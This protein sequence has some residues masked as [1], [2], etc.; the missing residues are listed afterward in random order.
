MRNIRLKLSY[1]LLLGLGLSGLH[2]QES[3]NA[4]GGN[5]SGSGGSAAYSIGQVVCQFSAGT[6]GSEAQGVQQPYEISVVTTIKE[7]TGIKLT[8]FAWP[9]P[10]AGPLT[11]CIIEP[12]FSELSY[13]LSDLNGKILLNEKIKSSRTTIIMNNR[14]P[15]TYFLKVVR[16]N[17]EVKTFKIIKIQ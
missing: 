17:Q 1:I 7:T 8:L 14:V 12:E 15:A 6:N 3:V 10:T 13:Q 11:L 2:A 9:N 16:G 5:A 4:A